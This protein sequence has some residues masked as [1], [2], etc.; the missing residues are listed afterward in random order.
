M[1]E[2]IVHELQLKLMYTA[3]KLRLSLLTGKMATN[4]YHLDQGSSPAGVRGWAQMDTTWLQVFYMSGMYFLHHNIDVLNYLSV[5]F[6]PLSLKLVLMK[7]I[8]PDI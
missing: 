7:K 5:L 2:L 8:H 1:F 4:V 3:C 6:Y